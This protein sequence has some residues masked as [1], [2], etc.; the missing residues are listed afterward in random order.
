MRPL[1]GIT[2]V[3]VEQAV[4]AP[5]LEVQGWDWR[6]D[7]VSGLGEH[8]EPVLVTWRNLDLQNPGRTFSFLRTRARIG[9]WRAS[10]NYTT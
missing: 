7:P 10:R 2:V 4:S 9:V 1:S 5:P 6:L 8:N 3:A